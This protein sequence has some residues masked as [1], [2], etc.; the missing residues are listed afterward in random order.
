M[1]F[2]LDIRTELNLG[3]TWTDVSPDVYVRDLKQISR[4]LRDMG[5]TADPSSLSLTLNNKGGKYSRRNAMSPLYG[6]LK[7]NTQLRLSIPG[8]GDSY[9]QLDGSPDGYAYTADKAALDTTGDIDVRIELEGNW[10]GPENQLLIGKW[11]NANSQQSWAFQMAPENGV[12]I[13]YFRYSQDGQTASSY[14]FAWPTPELPA[15]AALRA[16]LDIDNGKGGATVT[17]YWASSLAGPWNLIGR[18]LEVAGAPSTMF[19]SNA[20]LQI[21]LT[22]RR[23]EFPGAR[24]RFPLIGRVYRAEVRNGIGGAVVA[25]PDFRALA[26]KSTGVTDAQGNVWLLSG[27]AEIRD[28]EDRFVGE[29]STW[30]LKWSTDDSDVWTPIQVNGPMRRLGQGA[31]ALD[32]SLRR[33]IPSGN[34]VAYW[35]LEESQDA[36]RAYSPISGVFPASMTGV[37]WAAIDTLPSSAPLPKLEASAAFVGPVPAA[38]PGAWQVEFVYNADNIAPAELSNVISFTS[39]DGYIRRW[40][41]TARSGLVAIAGYD[42]GNVRQIF[43]GMIAGADIFASKWTRLRFWAQDDADGSGFTYRINFQDV[44]GDAG[45]LTGTWATGSCGSISSVIGDWGP[46]TAGWGVGHIFVLDTANTGLIDGSDDA[47]LGETTLQRMLR[48]ATEEGLPFSRTPGP[49]TP[50]AVGYQRPDTL[51]NLFEA[52]AAADGGLLSEDMRRVALH[53]RDRSS[54]YTQE[55]RLTLSYTAPG[56]GPDLEPVDDDTDVTNDVTVTRDGGSSGRAVLTSG[57][58]SVQAPPAGIGKYDAAFTLSLGDDDQASPIAYWK[59]FHGTWDAAR[60]PTVTLILHKPG[61]ESLIPGVLALREGDLIRLTNLPEWLSHEDVD[62]IVVGWSE[63]LDLYRWE[64]TLNCVPAGPWNTAVTDHATYGKA[65]TDGSVLEQSV[66]TSATALMVRTLAGPQWTDE[67]Q[68]LPFSIRVSG[69]TMQVTAVGPTGVDAFQRTV[70]NGWGTADSGQVWKNTGGAA[71]DRSVSTG[72]GIITI[73][74]SISSVRAQTLPLVLGDAEVRFRIS[75][76]QVSTGASMVP[77][78]VFRWASTTD[79]YRARVHFGTGGSMFVSITRGSTTLGSQPALPFSYTAGAVFEVR[80]QAIGHTVRIKVWQVGQSEPEAWN[81]TATVTSSPIATGEV[82]LSA[83]GF[84]GN[85][86][87]AP[88]FRFDDF[89]ITD[90]QLFTVTRSLNGVVKSHSAGEAVNIANPAFTSL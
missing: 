55:P 52:A 63:S 53:Y 24:Q 81:H 3:G 34:P 17:Y 28:R 43:K 60:F 15:R 30:P 64:L 88:A 85:T 45:G 54:M 89:L 75:A 9:L 27:N 59:L 32:S 86:N 51:L 68:D 48:L 56:L 39:A 62:L 1:S 26:D 66:T 20:P 18:P 65:D 4:G 74:S 67:A 44:G 25:S 50:E 19:A 77:G 6:K 73:P 22:D 31:K 10:Y 71:S 49:L 72:A 70:S 16:T 47:Y 23:V 38:R 69:E 42:A 90:T 13:L 82:G 33:R 12:P 14:Y 7:Q 58:L 29:V 11:D 37:E 87:T 36:T 78:A 61:A 2:P 76:N 79:C 46:A 80:A 84:T 21:G 41:I 57:P 5:T 83:S 40:D 8:T 35:P